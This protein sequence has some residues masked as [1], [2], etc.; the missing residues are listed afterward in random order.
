MRYLRLQFHVR[1]DP[2]IITP[3]LKKAWGISDKLVVAFNLK[4][5]MFWDN[6]GSSLRI[7]RLAAGVIQTF[8]EIN[9]RSYESFVELLADKEFRRLKIAE[10]NAC[11]A[12]HTYL[13]DH[14]NLYYSEWMCD[15]NPGEIQEGIRCEDLQCLTYPDDYFE[16]F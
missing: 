15:I 3:Q 2:T 10:I 1:F 16:L 5:G 13:R 6:C 4:E 9:G 12:L 14:P 8:S 11:G 7:R